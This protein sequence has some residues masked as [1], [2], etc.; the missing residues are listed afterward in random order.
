VP[1]PSARK[2]LQIAGVAAGP[3]PGR[4]RLSAPAH[5]RSLTIRHSHRGSRSLAISAL[6]LTAGLLVGCRSKGGAETA[7][8]D[9]GHVR[10]VPAA[11]P[12]A[13]IAASAAPSSAL[14]AT[15]DTAEYTVLM[16]GRAAGRLRQWPDTGGAITTTFSFNDRGRGPDLRQT[17]RLDR[18]GL[19]SGMRLTGSNYLRLPVSESVETSGQVLAWRNE[20]AAGRTPPGA[21]FYLPIETIPTDIAVLAR[22][23]QRSPTRSVPLLPEG[24]AS[25][26]TSEV[27]T[28]TAG[29]RSMRVT[30]ALISGLG[31]TP[32]TVWLDEQ[33]RLFA[34]GSSWQM[35]IR[36]G[37]ESA[38]DDLVAA[39]IDV[40]RVRDSI[41]V[42]RRMKP[43]Q[44]I[45]V[46]GETIAAVGDDGAVA[47]PADVEIVDA[48]NRAVLPGLW[49]MHV[50]VQ[51]DDG[52]LHLAAGVTTVRDLA[53]DTDELTARVRRFDTGALLGPRVLKAGFMDGPGPFAG[54]TKVLVSTRDEARAAVE[55]YADR[56][57]EQ[58]K[59]YS[60]LDPA[61]LPTIVRTAHQ[62]GLRVSGH[63]PNGMTAEQMVR[64]GAD[65][66]QHA[67]F[68]F[69]N[70]LTDS[71]VDT[72]TPARFTTVARR[73]GSVDQRSEAM[74][75]FIALLKERDVVVDPT[76]NVFESLFTSRPGTL[77]QASLPIA[78]R[79]PPV[80]RRSL[81]TGGLP[82]SVAL[83]PLHRASF[84][85]ME[86]LVKRLHEAGVRLVA[87][88]DAMA[89]F[90]LHRELELYSEAGIP[91]LDILYIATL[92]AARVMKHDARW[93]SIEPGKLADLVLV[94]GDPSQRM[95]DLRRAEL[96]MKG[97][98]IY[99]PDSLY[100][101][102]GVKPAPHKGSVP[103]RQ[104]RAEDV[105]CRGPAAV[106]RDS[107]EPVPLNC[108]VADSAAASTKRVVPRRGAA[109]ARGAPARRPAT[110]RPAPQ[111]RKPT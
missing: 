75:K 33:G 105:V 17:L 106:R 6:A 43:S 77:D 30:R 1:V 12:A 104:V 39:Q 89:G 7:R 38:A 37:F 86:R 46:R 83:E 24:T 52:I 88:T 45:I 72:R 73:A 94:D 60:S 55:A 11:L 9:A 22:A 58:I 35:V 69:L 48:A 5:M 59:V 65:E 95:R 67:N 14:P 15:G 96:V 79:L 32:E 108:V 76:L 41:A 47:L 27:R 61:L 21:A 90:S 81:L 34:S 42:A 71:A 54:P 102:L 100:A 49:D 56:G 36:R 107:G 85:A 8:T 23:L 97:G 62:R 111:V 64:A 19:P 29:T 40:S 93:G 44:T 53:N 25:V 51:D 3:T 16:A 28:I 109:P 84:I 50:H 80:A 70:F 99:V 31:L 87:G 63:V 82:V 26:G 13:S 2:L 57:Y 92:G 110:R 103:I 20:S 74:Q 101:S 66:L 98:V 78:V 4:A 91:N 10:S 68:L 18:N